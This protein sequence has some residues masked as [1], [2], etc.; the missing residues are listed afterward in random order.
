MLKKIYDTICHLFQNKPLTMLKI[1]WT[2]GTNISK[3]LI[4]THIFYH[5]R[6]L[7]KMSAILFYNQCVM[8]LSPC[9][10]WHTLNL[11]AVGW[12]VGY[13]DQSRYE[14][15][16]WEMLLQSNNISHWLGAY[17][18]WSQ[19]VC[20][21]WKWSRALLASEW[22]LPAIRAMQGNCERISS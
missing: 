14:P 12:S 11:V 5:K 21:S 1:N 8:W 17:L 4:K 7:C 2:Q 15:S 16:Q 10:L 13:R 22:K 20:H 6:V 18:D 3:I 19:G 9:R